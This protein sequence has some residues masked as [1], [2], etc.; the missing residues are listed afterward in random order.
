MLIYDVG[1]RGYMRNY[2]I[3]GGGAK[4][5]LKGVFLS[6]LISTRYNSIKFNEI[7]GHLTFCGN[8][9]S[10]QMLYSLIYCSLFSVLGYI[11]RNNYAFLMGMMIIIISILLSV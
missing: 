3:A 8:I 10:N 7:I 1:L 6:M 2:I 11:L 5:H 4:T 9:H